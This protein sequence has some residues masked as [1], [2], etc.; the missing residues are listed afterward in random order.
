MYLSKMYL[1]FV[2]IYVVMMLK[3]KKIKAEIMRKRKPLIIVIIA[4]QAIVIAL[5]LK[6]KDVMSNTRHKYET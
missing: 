3:I 6:K 5:H 4:Y 2:P 1:G